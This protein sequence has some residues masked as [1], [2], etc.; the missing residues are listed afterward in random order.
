MYS[1]VKMVVQARFDSY[2]TREAILAEVPVTKE[3]I[4]EVMIRNHYGNLQ[5]ALPHLEGKNLHDNDQLPLIEGETE[6][7]HYGGLYLVYDGEKILETASFRIMRKKALRET[8]SVP[9]EK[10]F[11]AQ[12]RS[13][14]DQDNVFLYNT[15]RQQLTKVKGEFSNAFPAGKGSLD[16]LLEKYLPTNFMSANGS[17]PAYE[18]GTKTANA[19]LTAYALNRGIDKGVRTIIVKRTAYDFG[20]GKL[21]EFGPDG[22]TREFFFKYDSEHTG[23]FVDEEHKIVGV[24]REYQHK[25]GKQVCTSEQ[26]VS[27]SAGGEVQY[28]PLSA[29]RRAA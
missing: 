22:L 5:S 15:K 25:R 9:S 16:D 8:V 13:G 26:Y 24:L 12:L 19:L 20:M 29:Y 17:T 21:A 4:F 3:N 28:S 14:G 27:F 2:G 7:P 11:L 1:L 18:V 10:S 23:Q 6:N